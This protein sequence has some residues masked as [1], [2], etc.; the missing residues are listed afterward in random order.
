VSKVS[1]H[2][3]HAKR[4][5]I[6]FKDMHLMLVHETSRYGSVQRRYQK[7]LRREAP[8]VGRHATVRVHT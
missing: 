7:F 5:G 3:E 1:G 8:P 4:P 2:Q 6:L